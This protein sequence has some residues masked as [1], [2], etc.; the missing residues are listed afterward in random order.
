MQKASNDGKV[1]RYALPGVVDPV[2]EEDI[3][4]KR[5]LDQ[6]MSVA[7]PTDYDEVVGT[8]MTDTSLRI[9]LKGQYIY[10]FKA[11]LYLATTDSGKGYKFGFRVPLSEMSVTFGTNTFTG[12]DVLTN[13]INNNGNI[14][15]GSLT[16]AGPARVILEGM[17][18]LYDDS[19]MILQMA[20]LI[21]GGTDGISLG[22]TSSMTATQVRYFPT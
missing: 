17:A 2:F 3:V 20:Q 7:F 10:N 15:S 4:N 11:T 8:T 12:D 1:E 9:T 18:Y 19:P 16:N 5:F 14:V 6:R 22:I 13:I 21:P